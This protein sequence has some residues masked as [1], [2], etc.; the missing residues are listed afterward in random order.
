MFTDA[1][2]AAEDVGRTTSG[3]TGS[4]PPRT[5]RELQLLPQA[6]Q[7]SHGFTPPIGA[8]S[9][10]VALKPKLSQPL[11]LDLWS[12]KT[13]QWSECPCDGP[14]R[15]MASSLSSPP[16]TQEPQAEARWGKLSPN[17]FPL[18]LVV[19]GAL[20]QSQ[21]TRHLLKAQ[22]GNVGQA[23]QG[24]SVAFIS[25][26]WGK[27]RSINDKHSDPEVDSGLH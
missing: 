4:P 10:S 23:G 7:L 1:N 25:Q 8:L 3:Q 16:V 24:L 18:G 2:Q 21:G 27:D 13:R 26:P 12:M 9:V 20:L 14:S 22:S 11:E 15:T 6:F 5:H 19:S 17:Q